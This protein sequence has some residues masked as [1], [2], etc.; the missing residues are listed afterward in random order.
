MRQYRR[1]FLAAVVVALCASCA[2]APSSNG[3]GAAADCAYRVAYDGRQ[4]AGLPHAE[5]EVGEKLGPAVLPPCDDTPS[6]GDGPETPEPRTA[7][8]V[9][10]V[11]PRIAITLEDAPGGVLLV[12][13]DARKALP[14]EVAKLLRRQ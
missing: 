11:D 10:G 2:G 4:Y 9:K 12:A 3:G 14:P 1:A 6:D 8:A 5:F 13:V 7:Y